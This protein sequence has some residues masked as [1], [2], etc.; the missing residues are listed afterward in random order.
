MR[1]STGDSNTKGENESFGYVI[2]TRSEKLTHGKVY[3]EFKDLLM[4]FVGADFKNG[5]DIACLIREMKDPEPDL[6]NEHEPKRP[7]KGT[8]DKYDDFEMEEWRMKYKIFL[9]HKS[10]MKSN[11]KKLYA[12]VW[13]QCTQ[14]LKS[15][16]MGLDKYEESEKNADAKW[17]LKNIKLISAGVDTT[18]NVVVTYHQ[19]F[20]NILFLRQGLSESMEDYLKRFNAL[21]ETTKLAGGKN[22]WYCKKLYDK[23]LQDATNDEIKT[24]TEKVQ[25]IF[26][27]LHGD[28]TRFGARIRELERAMHAGRDEWPKLVVAAYHLMIKTQEQLISEELRLSRTSQGRGGRAQ[29]SSQF[30]QQDGNGG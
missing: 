1:I 4:T 15:E 27:L 25:A 17:L 10:I 5:N 9:E 8:G 13:G 3:N 20:M 26:F 28:K 22:L 14:A 19:Q 12:L 30:L 23:K 24:S 21:T 7:L 18:V 11:E 29:A 16:L 2:G 6:R